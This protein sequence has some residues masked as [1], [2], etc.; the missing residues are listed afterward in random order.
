LNVLYLVRLKTTFYNMKKLLL[1]ASAA[2][3][4]VGAI[5]Q[6]CTPDASFVGSPAGLYPAGPLGPSCELI[7]PKTIISLTDTTV[8]GIQIIGTATLYITRMR[9]NSVVGLPAGLTLSTDVMASMDVDGPWGYW[10]NTGAT[11]NQTAAFGCAFVTGSGGD[12]DNAVGGGPNSDGEYPLVFEVDAYV[13]ATEPGFALGF[14]GGEQWVSTIDASVGGGAF[15]ILDTLVVPTDY[16]DISTTIAGSENVDPA[17][18][19]TYSVPND[20]NVTYVWTATNGTI[21]AG[22]GTNEVTVEWA[23]SGSLEVDLTDDGC[24]GNDQKSITA[25]PTGLDEIAGIN[26]SVYPNPSNGLFNLQLD[27]TDALTVRIID[28]SGKVLRS[29]TISG[30]VVYT[31]DMQTAPAGVYI[32]ELETANGKTFKRLIKQ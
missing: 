23:G 30:S 1:I 14:I 10:D 18:P 13:A 5:A 2:F 20:P 27:N 12:W 24:S 4:S 22:Q 31:L 28:V 25:N 6:S 7:A 11:P 15:F 19:E 3:F 21:T 26:A 32:L 17:T 9:I 29:N 8:T 16:A